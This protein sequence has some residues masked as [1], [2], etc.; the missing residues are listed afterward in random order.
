MEEAST[1]TVLFHLDDSMFNY[2]NTLVARI[3]KLIVKDLR[4][5]I[6][7]AEPTDTVV[8]AIIASSMEEYSDDPEQY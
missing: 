3:K 2:I 8:Q 7:S 1:S 5:L 4:D 6:G